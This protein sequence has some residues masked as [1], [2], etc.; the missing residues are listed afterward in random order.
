MDYLAGWRRFVRELH[1]LPLWARRYHTQHVVRTARMAPTALTY[2]RGYEDA[3]AA[4][5]DG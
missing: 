5:V 4:T 3:A 2:W 1:R